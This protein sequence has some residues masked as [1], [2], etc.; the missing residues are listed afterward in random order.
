MT[1]RG[2]LAVVGTPIGNLGDLSPRA[3]EVLEAADVICCEDTRR[4]GRLLALAGIEHGRLL[5]LHG[6]NEVARAGEVVR[7]VLEGRRVALVTD[8][9]MPAVSDP[10]ARVVAAVHDAGGAVTAVPGPSAV[11]AAVALSGFA[12]ARFCFEGFVPRRGAARRE[13]L[14]AIASSSVPT[15]C[16]EAPSRVEALLGDLAAACGPERLVAV[17][18]ELTKLHEEVW[19]G[20]LGEAAGRWPAEAAKG[21]FVVV[22]SAGAFSAPEVP[23]DDELAALV[24]ELVSSGATRRDAVATVAG[25]LGLAR[26]IVYDAATSSKRCADEGGL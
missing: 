12:E 18:R 10:G 20:P 22:V 8:A 25:R 16:Y 26:R 7:L 6:H 11:V 19:R 4:S 24:S 9:G 15:V 17:C 5:A 21:E 1:D 3:R 2:E 14:A 23:A 13:R